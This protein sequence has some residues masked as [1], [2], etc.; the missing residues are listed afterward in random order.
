M[1]IGVLTGGGDVPGLNPCIKAVTR[2][3]SELGWEVVGIRRG[4]NGLLNINMDDKT[5]AAEWLMPLTPKNVRTIDRAGG[6]ILHT[7]RINPEKVNPADVPAFLSGRY[8]ASPGDGT[9]D[10]TAHVLIAARLYREGVKVMS[11]PKTMDNDVYGTDCCIGF[12]TAVSRSSEHINRL[13][14]SAGSHERIA[15]IEL[16][17][18]NSGETA[19]ISGYLADVDRTLIAELPFDTLRLAELL[20]KD[21]ADN[22]SNYAMVVIS[23]GAKMLGGEVV[24]RGPADAYGNR[25]LGGIGQI[26]GDEL[27]RITG[28]DT[29]TQNLGYI[30]RSGAPDAL[31]QM[32]A[33]SYGM[34]AIQILSG[35][36]HGLMM[37]LRDGKYTTVPADTC[38]QG[39]K[40]VD[41]DELYDVE[42]YRPRITRAFGKP[43]FLY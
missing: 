7:S 18:R 9:V 43:M 20:V 21:R 42:A 31:D 23:E 8:A 27:S 26:L 6:T 11:I 39:Q 29:I 17:G 15:V 4:W 32:V 19:L 1:R 38:L 12:S 33:K 10:C 13:R 14:T 22:P 30:M 34:M 25:K 36:K 2:T 5:S 16:F 40:R 41:I 28:I 35:D 37:A 24:Q 3:A